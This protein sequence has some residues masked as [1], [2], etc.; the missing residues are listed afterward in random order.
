M[1]FS[2]SIDER[3]EHAEYPQET[4]HPVFLQRRRAGI[5]PAHSFSCAE[6]RQA[7]SPQRLD[8][9]LRDLV[10]IPFQ[11]YARAKQLAVLREELNH[12]WRQQF[13]QRPASREPS[14]SPERFYPRDAVCLQVDDLVRYF[15]VGQKHVALLRFL[16]PPKHRVDRRV[17]LLARGLVDAARVYPAV[18]YAILGS[19]VDAEADLRVAALVFAFVGH[20][21]IVCDFLAMVPGVR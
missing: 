1:L 2:L 18:L 19:S 15:D 12:S 8:R 13:L 20:E 21:L 11:R 4:V 14:T 10:D 3:Q 7:L 5:C 9:N 17:Q 6:A 16:V